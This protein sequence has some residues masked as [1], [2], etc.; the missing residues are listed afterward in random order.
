LQN[1]GT[2]TWTKSYTI[3]LFSG[4]GMGAAAST[5]LPADV[6]PGQSVDISVDMIAPAL[7]STSGATEVAQLLECI[8]HRT[9]RWVAILGTHRRQHFPTQLPPHQLQPHHPLR[10][11]RRPGQRSK[12]HGK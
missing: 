11:N 9:W 3:S 4:D 2:C 10:L 7:R 12:N 5:T 1:A 8:R 6:S